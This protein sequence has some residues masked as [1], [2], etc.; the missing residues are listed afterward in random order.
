MSL[1]LIVS[2]LFIGMVN[3]LPEHFSIITHISVKW[4]IVQCQK[5]EILSRRKREL[6][7]FKLHPYLLLTHPFL[8]KI[9][10]NSFFEKITL[11]FLYKLFPFFVGV[12]YLVNRAEERFKT[13]ISF[14]DQIPTCL[15]EKDY[16][17]EVL[18]RDIWYFF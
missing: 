17:F 5:Y 14:Q 18:L 7:P 16:F 4:N 8:L 10:F 9:E 11:W 3:Q 12:S 6:V 2:F 1:F 15:T 13:Y